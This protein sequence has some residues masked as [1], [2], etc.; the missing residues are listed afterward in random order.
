[1]HGERIISEG[2][3]V[4]GLGGV[5]LKCLTP[6]SRLKM[7]SLRSIN[8]QKFAPSGVD[9]SSVDPQL[10]PRV[11]TGQHSQGGARVK[12]DRYLTY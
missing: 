6:R 12:T 9:L 2:C 3:A 10:G 7:A 11:T 4:G 5:Y 8:K 1:M